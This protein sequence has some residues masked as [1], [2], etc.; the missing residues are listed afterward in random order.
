MASLVEQVRAK[1]IAFL[2]IATPISTDDLLYRY[3]QSKSGLSNKLSVADHCKAAGFHNAL[4][5]TLNAVDTIT[6][7]LPNGDVEAAAPTFSLQTTTYTLSASASSPISGTKSL[8]STSAT[9]G[10]AMG[11]YFGFIG[12][13]NVAAT[14]DSTAVIVPGKTANATLK[15][16]AGAGVF[17]CTAS[18]MTLASGTSSDFTGGSAGTQVDSNGSVQVV[19]CP[20]LVSSGTQNRVLL[21]INGLFNTAG[22]VQF[23]DIVIWAT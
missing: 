2:G 9:I 10:S 21:V 20:V 11:L 17:S 23:D 5:D 18:L 14:Y 1:A 22:T 3:W 6:N 16:K 19:T 7:L 15:M 13:I 12:D 8:L 4:N